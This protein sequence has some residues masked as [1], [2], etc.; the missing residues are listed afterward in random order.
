[1]ARAFEAKPAVRERVPLL[2]GIVGPSGGGKTGSALELAHGFQEVS[3][4]DIGYIDT[5]AKRAL[6][7]ADA[8]MF[9]NP[10]KRFKFQHLPFLA[11]FS[12]LDYLEAIEYFYKKG[13]KTIV[14][15]SMSHEHEGSGGVLEWHED[16]MKRMAGDDYAKRERV[17]FAAWIKPK[18]ARTHLTGTIL[19]MQVNLI[20]CFRAKEKIKI[21]KGQDPT[22]MGWQP[23][24]NPDFIYEMVVNFLLP[25]RAGGVP[26]WNP[27]EKAE[28]QMIKLPE[29]FKTIF[30]DNKPL[31]AAIGVKM[32]QWAAGGVVPASPRPAAAPVQAPKLAATV[33]NPAKPMQAPSTGV[34]ASKSSVQD[35]GGDP[36]DPG[37]LPL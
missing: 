20:S 12:P 3:G 24:G 36:T 25:P 27:E 7:Y 21:K 1:M 23:I 17:N 6:H 9:S 22:P 35:P 14:V 28:R 11:P 16:E 5:E 26:Q 19:Q 29:F 8:P 15:D 4:G 10:A 33:A 30:A 31:S 2:V 37:Q 34:P 13:V 18:A 32:A